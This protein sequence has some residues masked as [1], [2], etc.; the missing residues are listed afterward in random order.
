MIRI[1]TTI[2]LLFALSIAAFGQEKGCGF[3]ALHAKQLAENPAYAAK[4][5]QMD[6]AWSRFQKS[7]AAQ[8]KIIS[9]I[10]TVYEIPVVIHVIHTGNP[11]GGPN[12]PTDAKLINL[13]NYVNDAYAASWAGFPTPGNGGNRVPFRFVLAKRDPDCLPTTGINRIDG[14][15]LPGYVQDG[16]RYNATSPGVADIDIKNLSRW[17]NDRFYNIWLVND[18]SD[19]IAGYAYFPGAGP[20]VDGTVMMSS[21]IN[22]GG[23]TLVHELGHAMGLYHTF[24]GSSDAT[25]PPTETDCTMQGDR[26][27]DTE[28]HPQVIGCNVTNPCTGNPNDKTPHSLMSYTGGLCRDRF[29]GGQKQR[30]LFQLTN[31]RQS[32]MNSIGATPPDPAPALSQCTPS[33]INATSTLNVGPRNVTLSTLNYTSGGYTSEGNKVLAQHFCGLPTELLAG[34]T[35]PISV[36]TMGERQNVAVYIDYNNDGIFQTPG[37]LVYSHSGIVNGNETHSGQIIVPA[38]GSAM[39]QPLRMRVVSDHFPNLNP[40]PCGPYLHGQ[41]EDYPVRVIPQPQAP[42]AIYLT[43]GSNPGCKDSLLE[44]SASVGS[45]TVLW[46]VNGQFVFTGN[47]YQTTTLTNGDAVTASIV[48]GNGSCGTS[49]TAHSL[50]I[51]V[52][53]QVS[54]SIAP[55]ISFINGRLVSNLSPVQWFGPAGKIPGATNQSYLPSAIGYYYALATPSGCPSEASNRLYIG[56][57]DVKDH[58]PEGFTIHPNPAST[59]LNIQWAGAPDEW[60]YEVIDALGRQLHEATVRGKMVKVPIVMLPT[61]I[62]LLKVNG[63][64]EL[65]AIVKFVVSH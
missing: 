42:Q 19:N 64:E 9:G 10:D 57:L 38:M 40:S 5:V 11:I 65:T 27:C 21:Y 47:P 54:T 63:K 50:P 3:D 18:I 48:V 59:T 49:D 1:Y 22:P 31:Y 16:V 24:Q 51:V 32:L 45:Q 52:Q 37:E 58:L 14:S 33:I 6:F 12:N 25:C 17:P 60:H 35:Y 62:Y 15:V 29:T 46:Y 4:I 13:I 44:F 23:S 39:C 7:E 53:H 28:P 36:S 20:L 26:V 56:E 2:T 43:Q 34:N 55:F 8:R 61:G 30:M 41:A